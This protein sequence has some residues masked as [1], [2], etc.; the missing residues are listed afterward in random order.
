MGQLKRESL[1][2][3]D[4]DDNVDT[5]G[6][7]PA[8]FLPLSR[9]SDITEDNMAV[10]KRGQGQGQGRR[11]IY[12]Y[13]YISKKKGGWGDTCSVRC[14]FGTF[15]RTCRRCEMSSFL[16]SFV[17]HLPPFMGGNRKEGEG[18]VGRT[19]DRSSL[20]NP[21]LNIPKRFQMKARFPFRQ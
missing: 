3:P 20:K 16:Q 8:S 11:H 21:F 17:L 14:V 18:G 4:D 5:G 9:P 13:I 6:E 10:P 2:A 12:I 15:S 19:R 7:Q 1:L